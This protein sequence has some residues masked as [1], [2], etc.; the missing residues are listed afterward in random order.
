MDQNISFLDDGTRAR[1]RA[2]QQRL[3]EIWASTSSW[4]AKLRTEAKES[5]ESIL[6]LK[7]KY[8]EEISSFAQSVTQEINGIFD[9][10]DNEVL[11]KESKR[12]DIIEGNLAVFI[13]E[14]VSIRIEAQSG[15][16]SRQLK[17]AYETFDIEK[18]KEEKRY[19]FVRTILFELVLIFLWFRESKLVQR[20]GKHIQKTTQRFEDEAALTSSSCLTLEDD[21]HEHERR[22]ARVHLIRQVDATKERN[23][24]QTIVDKEQNTRSAEDVIVLDTLI[25]TQKLLQQMVLMH[26]G[27]KSD[28]MDLPTF[29]KL[30]ARVD[31]IQAKKTSKQSS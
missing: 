20:A 15:E 19:A 27:S 5:V 7:D 18:K 31:E 6:Q 28:E 26:F 30:T 1:N 9:K 25:E 8:N 23:M 12:V 21:I 24:L 2:F 11:P 16:V 17:R 14:T 13:K 29:D 22:S 10:F 4:E 3:D